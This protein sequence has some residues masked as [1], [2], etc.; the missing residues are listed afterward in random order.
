GAPNADAAPP[1]KPVNQYL[2]LRSYTGLPAMPAAV[3]TGKPL[4]CMQCHL[5]NGGS[6]PESAAIA[7]LSVNYI[8]EQV[9]AFRDGERVDVRTGRMVQV[10]KL[11]SEKELREAAEYYAAIGPDRQQWVKTVVSN[12][13]P[14]GPA[15]FG[16]GGFRYRAPEGGTDPLPLGMVVQ[17]AA[18]DDLVRAR[19][20][21][22]GGFVQYVNAEDLA[23]G[24]KV[25]AAGACGTCHGAAYKGVGDVPR[26]AG[27][28]TV[29]LI[30][31]LKDIQTGARKNKNAALMKPIIDKLS[32]REMVAVSAYLASNSP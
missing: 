21:I 30:R 13:V 7:G 31:Q 2:I 25:A 10:A 6:H 11:I 3:A 26:L 9:H 24:E 23:L 19:D 20:Q 1:S 17:T 16:G 5:A 4:P 14:K 22:D 12:E 15:P 29:Y 27:Q 18:D 32:D 28:H 8:I